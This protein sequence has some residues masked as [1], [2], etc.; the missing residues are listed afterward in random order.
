VLFGFRFRLEIYVPKDK[1]E[2]G[3]F[4]LP[5]LHGDR[6][7]GRVDPAM[8]RKANLLRV[9][10]VFAE[11]RAPESAGPAVA[12]AISRLAR[13]LGADAVEYTPRVPA[14]WRDSL[15]N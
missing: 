8:D 5:I 1:R 11:E 3:F 10:G 4:V 2:Y 12:K 13:W 7:I 9:N 14:A 6:L 15:R